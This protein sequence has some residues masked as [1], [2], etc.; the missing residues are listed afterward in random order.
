MQEKA[1]S[2]DKQFFWRISKNKHGWA[3]SLDL[4]LVDGRDQG[5]DGQNGVSERK[6]RVPGLSA[7][8]RCMLRWHREESIYPFWRDGSDQVRWK[9]I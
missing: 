7:F 6:S 8:R 4:F 1:Q 3:P 5:K 2:E 9:Q